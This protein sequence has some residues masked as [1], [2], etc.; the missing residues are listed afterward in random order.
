MVTGNFSGHNFLKRTNSVKIFEYPLTI[1]EGHLDTFGHVNNATYLSLYEEARWDF[2]TKG[3]FGLTEIQEKKM[4]PVV[5]GLEI[6]FTAELKN[7]E[8]ITITSKILGMKNP[9]VMQME[10]KMIKPDG[11]EASSMIIQFGLF[12][13]KKRKL[14]LPTK[15]WNAA[16]GFED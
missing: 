11:T 13:L 16:I 12:D 2:I 8:P 10:Q 7:R 1:I 14:V 5:L 4:G 6:K 15:E 9:L 3:G